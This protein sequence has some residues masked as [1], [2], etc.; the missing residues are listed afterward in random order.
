MELS[1]DPVG[2]GEEAPGRLE[3]R[4]GGGPLRTHS[5]HPADSV[6]IGAVGQGQ[7]FSGFYQLA[8][9]PGPWLQPR[10]FCGSI[11]MCLEFQNGA[12]ASAGPAAPRLQARSWL[13]QSLPDLRDPHTVQREG[14]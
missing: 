6:S 10:S 11:G 5:T 8:V 13:L 3:S 2:R 7:F 1:C 9:Q 4:R 14:E 12:A